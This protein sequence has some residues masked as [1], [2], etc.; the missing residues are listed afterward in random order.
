M[1]P[2]DPVPAKKLSVMGYI[3]DGVIDKMQ[4]LHICVVFLHSWGSYN[5]GEK[6]WMIRS[7]AQEVLN[8]KVARRAYI[9]DLSEAARINLLRDMKAEGTVEVK[10]E[11]APDTDQK[12]EPFFDNVAFNKAVKHGQDL[13]G[14]KVVKALLDFYE[15]PRGRGRSAQQTTYGTVVLHK[16]CELKALP[17]KPIMVPWFADEMMDEYEN[18]WKSLLDL[19]ANN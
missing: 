10:M 13:F 2:S 11:K 6:A 1:K 12:V 9:K 16:V 17:P 7:L 4:P 3:P 5:P 19:A 15:V 8:K 18:Q 14:S